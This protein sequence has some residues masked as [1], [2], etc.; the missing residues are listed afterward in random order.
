[1]SSLN[2][3]GV[4]I[5]RPAHQS[6]ELARLVEKAGGVPVLF[7]AIEIEPTVSASQLLSR[8][9]ALSRPDLAIVISSNAE[10]YGEPVLGELVA[11]NVR[12]AAIGPATAKTM[13]HLGCRPGIVPASGFNSEALLAE[14]EF[15]DMKGRRVL[16]LRGEGGREVLGDTLRQ[17]DAAVDY[18]EVY[19]RLLPQPGAGEV[20]KIESLWAEGGVRFV[21]T[22]SVE[23]LDNLV[24]LLSPDGQRLLR[25]SRIVTIS[26]QVVRKATQI[27]I[28][29]PSLLARS[30][31]DP[32][33]LEAMLG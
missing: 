5:T 17:R 18:L 7:P 12:L 28:A 4:L 22:N 16:I 23:T 10:N 29:A 27:G 33:M 25:A 14:D 21:A 15:R 8:F 19:R 31:N 13:Q 9:H 2:G 1:M 11:Q 6:G 3:A 24:R 20:R 26:E 30:P 32:A